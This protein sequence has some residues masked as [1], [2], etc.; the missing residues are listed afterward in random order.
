MRTIKE[1]NK[2]CGKFY[3]LLKNKEVGDKFLTA[4]ENEGYTFGDG[5][6]PTKKH[7]ANIMVVNDDMTINYAGTNGRIAFQC[8]A[9]GTKRIDY[10]KVIAGDSNIF[11][12]K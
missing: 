6:K 11:Y 12:E 10:S 7:F 3:V 5:A 8:N 2:E 9:T 1:I 4:A